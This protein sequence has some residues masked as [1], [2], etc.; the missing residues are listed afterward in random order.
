MF[1]LNKLLSNTEIDGIR[2][3]AKLIYYRDATT[4][5]L[6]SDDVDTLID[7]LGKVEDSISETLEDIEKEMREE[8]LEELKEEFS[9]KSQLNEEE[10]EKVFDEGYDKGYEDGTN[11]RETIGKKFEV[12]A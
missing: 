1:N 4:N 7:L 2:E 9:S 5:G 11:F 10:K 3:I 12:S 8:I 6:S